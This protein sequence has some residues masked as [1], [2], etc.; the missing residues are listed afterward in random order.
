MISEA[1]FQSLPT[2]SQST[3][4]ELVLACRPDRHTKP[5]SSQAHRIPPIHASVRRPSAS[6]GQAIDPATLV[7]GD[8]KNWEWAC[9]SAGDLIGGP[10]GRRQEHSLR[11]GGSGADDRA[12]VPRFVPKIPEI[13]DFEKRFRRSPDRGSRR[14]RGA[15]LRKVRVIG[16]VAQPWRTGSIGLAQ[17]QA[18]ENMPEIRGGIG[19]RIERPRSWRVNFARDHRPMAASAATSAKAA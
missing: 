16:S 11:A 12:T 17:R 14:A 8:D 9:K 13:E 5:Q 1:I 18:L 19:R 2:L 15:A 6:T 7:D 10:A 3:I 4:I